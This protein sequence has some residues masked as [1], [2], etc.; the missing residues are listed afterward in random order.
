ML[1]D[2]RRLPGTDFGPRQQPEAVRRDYE[3]HRGPL[4]KL[5][6][7]AA[8]GLAMLS[9]GLAPVAA[10]RLGLG[11]FVLKLVQR[12]LAEMKAGRGTRT[13]RCQP[14]GPRRRAGAPSP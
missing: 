12:Y 7:T 6:E 1:P 11:G 3:S 14:S 4:P 2:D 5:L 9:C 10:L 8:V 13:G